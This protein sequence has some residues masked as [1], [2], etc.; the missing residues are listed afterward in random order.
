MHDNGLLEFYSFFP[1]KV[2]T[3]L[4][5]IP[6]ESQDNIE[7]IRMRLGQPLTITIGQYEYPILP[8]SRIFESDLQSVIELA[9]RHSVHTVMDQIKNG[10]LTVRGGHRI[11][12]CGEAITEGGAIVGFRKISSINFRIA[13]EIK[14]IAEPF[15]S[16]LFNDNC[17]LNTLIIAPPGTGKTTFLRD[18]IRCISEGNSGYPSVRVGVSDERGEL[19]GMWE[20]IPQFD[21]GPHTDIIF[22]AK[23][24]EGAMTLLRGMS[25][26]VLAMDEIT[27][28][29][30]LD[31]IQFAAGCGVSLLATAHGRCL[32]EMS[33]RPLYKNL[34]ERRF[35]QMA[36][37]IDV[38]KTGKRIV[39]L[40][41][42]S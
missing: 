17:P 37:L 35:F 26:H 18:L 27:H 1:N 15:V 24:G 16:S 11:G 20:G 39:Q 33:V 28:P 8:E 42:I 9:S 12:L 41:E 14:G 13:K 10:F 25:P 7:E 30:D 5:V 22:G 32:K 2:R 40:E 19:S 31:A 6:S 29:A 21:L 36:I 3:M 34:F 38:C 23:K 4:Q